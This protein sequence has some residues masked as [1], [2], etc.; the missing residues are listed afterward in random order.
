MILESPTQKPSEI[1][2][3][4]RQSRADEKTIWVDAKLAFAIAKAI[5][6]NAR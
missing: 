4:R 2:S 1:L 3:C 5:P 6:F